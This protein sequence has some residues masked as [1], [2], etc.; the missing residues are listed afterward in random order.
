M[1]KTFLLILF[2][3]LFLL[4]HSQ[5]V[6]LS[7][8]ETAARNFC[9]GL[10]SL[11]PAT[12]GIN[13][14]PGNHLQITQNGQTLLYVFNLA[15]S[16]WVMIATDRN[17]FPVPAYSLQGSYTGENQPPQFLAWV[18]Q[19]LGQIEYAVENPIE[20]LQ[21][22][23][24]EWTRL[25]SKEPEII[26]NQEKEKEV[27]PMLISTW[28]QGQFYNQMCPPDPA[29][30]AGHCYTGCVATAMGQICYFFR[31]PDAGV[32]SYSYS[33]PDYGTISANFGETTY[34]W[35][36]MTNSVSQQ[37]ESV[38]ELL[39]HMG[40]SV[41]MDYGPD[42]SGMWNHKAAYSLRTY[43]KFDPQTQY[44]YRDSTNLDWDSVIV[45][46]LDQGI[47]MYYAGWSVPNV[48]GHAFVC[49]GYQTTDYFHFNWGWGGSYDGYFYLDNLIPG[50]SNFNLAQELIINAFPDTLN[51]SYPPY[52][53]GSDT[54]TML[55]GTIDD[56][57]GPSA[58]YENSAGCFWLISP[59]TIEDSVTSIEIHFDRFETEENHD[60]L[61]IYDGETTASPVLG[62][63]S[64][65]ALPP[66]ISSTGNKVLIAF[67]SDADATADGWFISYN[68][69]IPDW[70]SGMQ[71]ITAW[72]DTISDGSGTFY[73]Q[74]GTIC[75]WNIQP[76][77]ATEL[78]LEFTGFDTEENKD[79]VKIYDAGSNQLI[80]TY[81]GT[82][83]AGNLPDPVSS[84]SGKMLI[85]FS[86]NG[87]VTHQGWTAYFFATETG[88]VK[89]EILSEPYFLSPNPCKEKI[90]IRK[91]PDAE[92]QCS[93][94]ITDL[95]GTVVLSDFLIFNTSNTQWIELSGL[96]GGMY[97][98]NL[99][100][101][102]SHF[103]QKIVK[104]E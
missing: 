67:Q 34:N 97:I 79:L 18:E 9:G 35:Y 20:P 41:D 24:S 73:Y 63:F 25:L 15:P 23:I 47:P 37:N 27:V 76:A 69:I 65:S 49:D 8:A 13:I 98:I 4:T 90:L 89:K 26:K 14:N 43:F 91:N 70:C 12:M 48:N 16:G 83:S 60:F 51:Y 102:L 93:V 45:A 42:G 38:A 104:V 2:L 77:G 39:Y 40:V 52:C 22:T 6:T 66:S 5:F 31:S 86:T 68:S 96:R 28:D 29:G 62:Q 32:G 88:I 56:G 17:V 103:H 78:T 84:P 87:T 81:S 71:M 53:S 10:N 55:A 36:G 21:A 85:T 74:N 95:S 57:S 101:E 46:H 54:L 92:N 1:K 61:T 72:E 44:L 75:M 82:Y 19:Y 3:Q 30:P 80:A 94:T 50:G 33:H 7:D 99:K 64:G 100:G 11:H 58:D 59:Q